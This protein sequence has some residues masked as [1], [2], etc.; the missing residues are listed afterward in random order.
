MQLNLQLACRMVRIIRSF[1]IWEESYYC[2]WIVILCMT[3]GL[4]LLF[5]PW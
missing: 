2:F 4:V 5:I 3:G 1:L